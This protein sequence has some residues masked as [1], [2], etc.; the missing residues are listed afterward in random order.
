MKTISFFVP[1]V[2][3][4]RDSGETADGKHYTT[5]EGNAWREKIAGYALSCP[6]RPT[7]EPHLGPVNVTVLFRLQRPGSHWLPS[8]ELSARG[9]RLPCHT[10]KPDA[11]NLAK[12]LEDAFSAGTK[13]RRG[14]GW[15]RDDA[16]IVSLVSLKRWCAQEEEPGVDITIRLSESH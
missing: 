5:R 16:Q 14:L 8:G 7:G 10:C 4:G 6:N 13:T 9:R 3:V 2:P 1:D 15:W 12:P 11:S